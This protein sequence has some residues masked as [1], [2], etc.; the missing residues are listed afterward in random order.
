MRDR[1]G[2]SRLRLSDEGEDAELSSS[3]GSRYQIRAQGR[4]DPSWSDRLGGLAITSDVAGP[5]PITTLIGR[6]ADQ[7]A[8]VG[9]LNALVDL[10]L[11]VLS[12]DCLEDPASGAR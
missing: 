11:T 5:Q 3:Q 10:H 2:G 1:H 9:I 8:L 6:V 12:V 7:S 4:L